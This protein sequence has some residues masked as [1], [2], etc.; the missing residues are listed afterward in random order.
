[1]ERNIKLKHSNFNENLSKYGS[2]VIMKKAVLLKFLKYY[3]TNYG[4]SEV[5]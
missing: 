3:Y 4:M 2:I 1:M 5:F